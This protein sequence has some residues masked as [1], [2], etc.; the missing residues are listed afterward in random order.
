MTLANYTRSNKGSF[1]NLPEDFWK[2]LDGINLQ[3]EN[4]TTLLQSGGNVREVLNVEEREVLV[5]SDKEIEI[6]LQNIKGKVRNA[7]IVWSSAY[8]YPQFTWKVLNEKKVLVKVKWTSTV[9]GTIRIRFE[10]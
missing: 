6:T 10:G 5:K 3:I 8:D 7:S 2:V 4:I 1:P 9:E